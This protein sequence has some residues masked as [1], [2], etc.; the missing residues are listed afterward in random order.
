MIDTVTGVEVVVGSVGGGVEGG[1]L[2]GAAVTG[3]ED[4]GGVEGGSPEGAA[5]TG[6]EDGARVKADWPLGAL[7]TAVIPRQQSRFI[8]SVVGQHS[9]VRLEAAQMG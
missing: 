5:V 3:T 8:P 1:S 9:P 7:G 4:G 6:T 2:V